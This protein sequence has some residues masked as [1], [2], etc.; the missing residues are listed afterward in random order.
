MECPRRLSARFSRFAYAVAGSFGLVASGLVY[1]SEPAA[2][3]HH[4]AAEV[5]LLKAE[6]A[7]FEADV[8]RDSEVIKR[9]FADEAIFVHANGVVQTKADYLRATEV[10]AIP[11]KSISTENRVVRIFGDVGVI[12]ATKHLVVGND[13]HLRGSYLSVY[14]KRDGRWQML[15]SQSAPAPV[16]PHSEKPGESK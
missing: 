14:I 2:S 16:N 6:D 11:V 4:T 13:L 15:D 7:L 5:S 12:R 9:G 3:L 10:A 1:G 8:K